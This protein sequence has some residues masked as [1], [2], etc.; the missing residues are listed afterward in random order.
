MEYQPC[1]IDTSGITLS[2]EIA[3]LAELLAK[4]THEVWAVNKMKEGYR[5]GEVTNNALKTHSSL[6]PY[7]SLTAAE[8]AYDVNTAIETIKVLIKLGFTIQGGDS[9]V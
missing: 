8:K 5:Y 4:N 7:E 1:P 6:V 9:H 3:A 2:N